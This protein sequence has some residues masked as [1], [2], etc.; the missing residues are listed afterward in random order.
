MNLSEYSQ[1]DAL[2]LAELVRTGQT[3]ARE[4]GQLALDGVEKVNPRLN[5]VIEVYRERV[6]AL[7]EGSLAEGPFTGVPFMLKDL[8]ATEA[9][10]KCES[11][12][13]LTE[14]MV[15]EQDNH[16]VCQFKQAG[17]NLMGRTT[18]P[19]FGL[20]PT[21]ESIISG[22]TANP[23]NPGCVAGGSS[24]G[25][26]AIVAAG[27]LPMAH[28]NDGGGSTRIPAAINGLVGL[29]T[30]RGRISYGPDGSDL[31]YPFFSDFA[32]SRSVRDSATLL[33]AVCGPMPGETAI[34]GQ[35][36]RPYVEELT[37]P[38]G[39]LRVAICPDVGQYRAH[40][41]AREHLAQTGRLL[42]SLGLHVEEATPGIDFEEY[43]RTIPDAWTL[44]L[45]P[46]VDTVAESLGRDP[47]HHTLE[48]VTMALYERSRQLG[49]AD[50]VRVNEWINVI[51]RQLGEFFTRYDLLLT[52]T[53]AT[54]TPQ[55]GTIHT[56]R[57]ISVEQYFDEAFGFVPYT[58]L[59]NA[60]GTPAIS[61]PLCHWRDGM[62]AGMH[63]MAPMGEEGRLIRLAAALE[64]AAPWADRR[65]QIH[66]GSD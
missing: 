9:G 43:W 28:A 55:L 66:V 27:A 23:W 50:Q 58:I 22:E 3:K 48:P 42:E 4:L 64:Q 21:T 18:T 41:E 37:H 34:Y 52:P 62:P 20:T 44:L 29:K 54:P 63:F 61:L 35:P 11:G 25:S 17:L 8:G 31:M 14:G 33:D 45:G 24:G 38:L 39:K 7:D 15:S 53:T 60:T 6:E 12:S 5:A 49:L 1:Y 26:G 32:V 57:P 19:E 10:R 47:G 16:L 36:E 51:S 56:N 13:R 59:N 2:G 40:P 65:P 30:S 46:L